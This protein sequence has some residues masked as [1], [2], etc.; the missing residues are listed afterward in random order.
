MH[1]IRSKLIS[2]AACLCVLAAAVP[3][4]AA[5]GADGE[6]PWYQPYM[7]AFEQRGWLD[8]VAA[9]DLQ[10]DDPVSRAQFASIV[11]R[12]AGLTEESGKIA[13][14]KDVPAGSPYRT[15]LAKAL[16][17]GYMV[18]DAGAMSPDDPL[19]R[20]DAAVMLARLM[21]LTAS[22]VDVLKKFSD[23]GDISSYARESAAAMA[24]AISS[25]FFS[26]SF[27][28]SLAN[29]ISGLS[30]T[31]LPLSYRPKVSSWSKSRSF[32]FSCAAILSAVSG[33]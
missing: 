7:D 21:K 32:V 25:S 16:A 9:D 23:S 30:V 8:G 19:T 31:L 5:S 11:N 13:D 22:D 10:P 12:A 20:Q 2:L 29:R 17:A 28:S 15:D 3:I 24:A 33:I 26:T 18:G 4:A 14:Y 27:M 6:S 1:R